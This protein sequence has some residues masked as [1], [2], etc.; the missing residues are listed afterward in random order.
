LRASDEQQRAIVDAY[1]ADLSIA[2]SARVQDVGCG[3]G[4]VTRAAAH[5]PGV[6][7]AVGVDLSPIF[8]AK[9]R[10]LSLGIENVAFLEADARA[11]P[12]TDPEFDV[13]VFHTTLTHV[14]EP[15][16]ALAE[17][18]RVLRP[19]GTVAIC[20][21]DYSTISVANGEWDPLHACVETAKTHSSTTSG[22]HV[23]CRHFSGVRVFA[24]R[25]R[26]VTA[27]CRFLA[28]TT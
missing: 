7:E 27:I 8:I 28:R 25:R 10:E 11:L 16:R 20:D 15:D 6:V 14:P 13:V 5:L 17:A 22:S 2:A 3:T 12:F 18:F 9:A 21:G 26:G 24:Y 4:F 23:A 1:L 19:G